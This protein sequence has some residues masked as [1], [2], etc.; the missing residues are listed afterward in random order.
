ALAA[1]RRPGAMVRA[2]SAA[3]RAVVVRR[4]DLDGDRGAAD[5]HVAHALEHAIDVFRWNVDERE[6]RV[7][8]DGADDA[9]GDVGLARDGA[10]DVARA[11]ARLPAGVDEEPDH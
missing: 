6:A 9:A 1:W 8:V 3:V 5:L 2:I 7:D 4:R 11:D 10:D